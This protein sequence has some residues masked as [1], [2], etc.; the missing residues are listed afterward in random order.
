QLS[1]YGNQSPR[2]KARF[3]VVQSWDANHPLNDIADVLLPSSVHVEKEGTFTNLQGRVQKIH[4]AYPPK[5]QAVAD[6][7]VFR[8][9]GV[10]LF[11]SAGEFHPA[12]IESL[13]ASL[14]SAAVV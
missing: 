6:I 5:G 14:E 12:A 11:P 8:R 13:V 7:E 4:Q 2:C 9:I 3:I 1:L 10:K